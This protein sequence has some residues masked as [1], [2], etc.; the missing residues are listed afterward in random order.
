MLL[1]SGLKTNLNA[2]NISLIKSICL[3]THSN[4]LAGLKSPGASTTCK[5]KSAV[6]KVSMLLSKILPNTNTN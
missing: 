3:Y 6:D 2:V 1:G 4:E 5:T